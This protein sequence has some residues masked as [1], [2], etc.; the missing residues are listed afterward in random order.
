[1]VR[2]WVSIEMRKIFAM[3]GALIGGGLGIAILGTAPAVHACTGVA[4]N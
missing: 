1:M 2:Y 4:L 3:I